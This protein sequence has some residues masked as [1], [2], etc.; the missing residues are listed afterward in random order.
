MDD[1]S[2][3]TLAATGEVLQQP[4][5]LPASA[6]EPWSHVLGDISEGLP[7]CDVVKELRAAWEA[8][9]EREAHRREVLAEYVELEARYRALGEEEQEGIAAEAEGRGSRE[10]W[11]RPKLERERMKAAADEPSKLRREN[12][13]EREARDAMSIYEQIVTS[14]ADELLLLL[15]PAADRVADEYA[16]LKAKFDRETEAI[17][18][19]RNR[20][21]AQIKEIV[22]RTP[23]VR[24][25]D[26]PAE[27][28]AW[29]PPLPAAYVESL[30]SEEVAA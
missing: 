1:R 9:G 15:K 18:R 5:R 29:R 6:W 13:A 14:H 7:E 4:A 11:E 2:V 19:E 25:T 27:G 8:V 30:L 3:T 28:E 23:G 12:L 10:D 26:F 20:L 22:G 24:V 21:G 17:Q 16:K